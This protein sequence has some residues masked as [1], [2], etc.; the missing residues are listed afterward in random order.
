M[1]QSS[2]ARKQWPD[3]FT[4]ATQSLKPTGLNHIG[5]QGKPDHGTIIIGGEENQIPKT[6]N[7]TDL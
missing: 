6:R 7:F 1:H 4:K 5:K 3:T 2:K